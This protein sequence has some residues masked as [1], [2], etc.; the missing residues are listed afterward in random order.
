[1]TRSWSYWVQ[2]PVSTT[3]SPVYRPRTTTNTRPLRHEAAGWLG[4]ATRN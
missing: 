3:S 1:M 4:N 2:L